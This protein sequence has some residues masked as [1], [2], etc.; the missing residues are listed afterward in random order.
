MR[1]AVDLQ[2][3]RITLPEVLDSNAKAAADITGEGIACGTLT[4]VSAYPLVVGMS[5]LGNGIAL[6][7]ELR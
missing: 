7:G 1:C 2:A 5:A 4:G 6:V 3:C